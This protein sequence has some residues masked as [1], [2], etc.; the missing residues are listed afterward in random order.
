MVRSVTDKEA[1]CTE[2]TQSKTAEQLSMVTAFMDLSLVYGNSNAE[3]RNIREFHNGR[4]AVANRNGHESLPQVD[5]VMD[6][7]NVPT[8]GDVCYLSGDSRTN[9]NP[10]IAMLHIVLMRE[11]NRI[12][13]VLQQVNSHWTDGIIFEEARRINIAQYQHISYYKWMPLVLGKC[14]IM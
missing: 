3:Q 13:N 14:V 9:E 5:N 11:H 4:L 12:A 2:S 6:I 1:N 8:Q 10:G 7:C